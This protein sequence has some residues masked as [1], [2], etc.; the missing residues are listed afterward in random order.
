MKRNHILGMACGYYLSRFDDSYARLGLGNM[1]MTHQAIGHALDVPPRSIQNWR[2]EFDPIH[3]NA[4]KGWW[5]RN[6]S[7]SR[8]RMVALLGDWDEDEV[9]ELVADA[10]ATPTGPAAL[11]YLDIAGDIDDAD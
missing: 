8:I 9:H 2:D 11:R 3:D 5:N 10:I 1:S 4:R 7:P 6:M